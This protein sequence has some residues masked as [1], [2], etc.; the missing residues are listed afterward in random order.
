MTNRARVIDFSRFSELASQISGPRAFSVTSL[1]LATT[2]VTLNR[3]SVIAF[4][5][6]DP[7]IY[8]ASAV[9]LSQ[10]IAFV[11]LIFAGKGILQ[12]TN[13][14][15]RTTLVITAY[16]VATILANEIIKLLFQSWNIDQISPPTW[17]IMLN[18]IFTTLIFLGFSWVGHF[19]SGNLYQVTTARE[20]VDELFRERQR[21]I[22]IINDGRNF[23]GRELSLEVEASRAA[24]ELC[25]S[26]YEIAESDLL[27]FESL[28]LSLSKIEESVRD[29]T[30]AL[31]N[32]A[33]GLRHR[34]GKYNSLSFMIDNVK[35]ENSYLPIA[36]AVISLFG[37]GTWLGYFVD[38]RSVL[39][40]GSALS[41]IGYVGFWMYLKLLAPKL[42]RFAVV[43][44]VIFFE[45]FLISYLFFWLL[46]LG[47]IAGD[48]STSYSVALVNAII[49]FLL[50]NGASV[51]GGILN[52][53]QIYRSEL[54]TKAS[55][56]R[57]SLMELET[58]RA[59]E[60]DSWKSL[61]AG[62][63]AYSPTTASVML[64]DLIVTQN[65]L[66]VHETLLAVVAIWK[67]VE[68]K[69]PVVMS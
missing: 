68:S 1:I 19:I 2:F 30:K 47:F 5:V 60:A 67:T 7:L 35:R 40:W 18:L 26:K 23:A 17:Q 65:E 51:I 55:E 16:F 54:L 29:K 46:L 8:V 22:Q 33:S 53:T 45:L 28:N 3:I 59:H 62:D 25:E 42:L 24:I 12:V 13:L 36:M 20:I 9:I 39:L 58:L 44:R 43:F 37:L 41:L 11:V 38:T 50:F 21:L 34:S 49:P 56:L 61:F 57:I 66:K 27:N 69:L 48:N 32:R 4:E 52:S 64:Q 6:S 10:M 63:I 31:P 15:V 14:A